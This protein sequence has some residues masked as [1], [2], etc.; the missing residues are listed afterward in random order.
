M[1]YSYESVT[2]KARRLSCTG[3]VWEAGRRANDAAG[4]R[5][6]KWISNLERVALKAAAGH[7]AG[8]KRLQC[9]ER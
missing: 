2:K 1:I 9:C 6:S 8:E 7:E 4:R 3:F 5:R